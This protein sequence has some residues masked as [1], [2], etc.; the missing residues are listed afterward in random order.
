MTDENDQPPVES[1]NVGQWFEQMPLTRAHWVAGLTLFFSFV[2]ESWEMMIII[3][4]S[5]SGGRGVRSRYGRDR[6]TDRGDVYRHDSRRAYL[7][8]AGRSPG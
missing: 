4:N 6:E 5:G 1:K 2:I 7:G 8:Q 3:F